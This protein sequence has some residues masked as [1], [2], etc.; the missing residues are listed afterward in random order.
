MGNLEHLIDNI[1]DKLNIINEINE[2]IFFKLLKNSSTKIINICFLK[3]YIIIKQKYNDFLKNQ[4]YYEIKKILYL[5]DYY[6]LKK[7]HNI[8]NSHSNSNNIEIQNNINI[9]IIKKYFNINSI[10]SVEDFN[11]IYNIIYNKFNIFLSSDDIYGKLDNYI[12]FL[13]QFIEIY[14]FDNNSNFYTLIN[15]KDNISSIINNIKK[16]INKYKKTNIIYNI[17]K[18]DYDICI[19]CSHK[20]KTDGNTSELICIY[21]GHTCIL[22]GTAF[23][24][25][26]LYKQEGGRHTVGT[27]DPIRH[28]KYWID[29]I[30]AKENTVIDDKYIKKIEQCIKRDNIKNIKNISIDQ[31]RLYLKET[32]LS[33][34][35]DHIPLIRKYITG[36]TPPQLTHSELNLLFNYFDKA[37]KKYSIVKDQSKLNSMYYPFV[38][39]KIIEIIVKCPIRRNG[40]LDCIHLQGTK[41]LIDNDRNWKKICDLYKELPYKPTDRNN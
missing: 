7:H 15:K 8:I 3:N 41:T 13:S 9:D 40:L 24:D 28:C 31:F 27:Y 21:C 32:K 6:F 4:E 14:L 39:R 34:L 18:I 29:R 33:K 10:K 23:E 25:E 38:I 36:I 37:I 5:T 35:N 17:N 12:Y 20:M 2:Y 11:K 22:L 19:N 26:H 1:N 16:F 30:Q